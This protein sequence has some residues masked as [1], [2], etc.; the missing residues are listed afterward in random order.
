MPK[1]LRALA[2]LLATGTAWAQT[3]PWTPTPLP[4]T[5]YFI[6]LPSNE[7]VL[8]TPAQTVDMGTVYWNGTTWQSSIVTTGLQPIGANEVL[9]NLNNTAQIPVGCTQLPPGFTI[10]TIN[11]TSVPMN[12]LANQILVTTASATAAWETIPN[13]NAT[14]DALQYN[15]T[16][17]QITCVTISSSGGVTI[18]ASAQLLNSGTGTNPPVGS[19]SLGTNLSLTGT[20]PSQTLNAASTAST[21]WNALVPGVNTNATGEFVIGTGASL[22]TNGTAGSIQA[23]LFQPNALVVSGT[24]PSA[25][26]SW[27]YMTAPVSGTYTSIGASPPRADQIYANYQ[28]TINCPNGGDI[29]GFLAANENLNTG[30]NGTRGSEFEI[31]INAPPVSGNTQNV[32]ALLTKVNMN[33]DMLGVY[34]EHSLSNGNIFGFNPNIFANSAIH[35]YTLTTTSEF[36][37]QLPFGSTSYEKHGMNIATRAADAAQGVISDEALVFANGNYPASAWQCGICFAQVEHDSP[38]TFSSTYLGANYR[39]FASN[40]APEVGWGVDFHQA[41]IYPGLVPTA[42]T[43][44]GT[45]ATLTFSSTVAASSPSGNGTTATVL[46]APQVV[47]P[48]VGSPL[49]IAGQTGAGYNGSFTITAS[50]YNSVSYA[51]TTTA[52]C[53]TNCAVGTATFNAPV[54]P[55]VGSTIIVQNM[56]PAAYDTPASG[57][58]VTGAT[59]TTIS[60]ASTGT[61]TLTQAGNIWSPTTSGAFVKS[62]GYQVDFQGNEYANSVNLNQGSLNGITG[63]L[64]SLT[65]VPYGGYTGGAYSP[66][67][68]PTITIDPP[69]QRA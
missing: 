42:A 43:G 61:G 47:P 44:T 10:T 40:Y 41:Q 27:M 52:N 62:K 63:S 37:V 14:N 34:G 28:D 33:S 8:G 24:G 53:G 22:G 58:I 66:G 23:T 26:N 2:L 25:A 35:A 50:T 30:W 69:R 20:F 57:A 49:T 55:P 6:N 46:I 65:I 64:Q 3:Y 48:A 67:A 31:T 18:P 32:N 12:T 68:F 13:C 56:K 4:G 15:T 16:N 54:V 1:I 39:Y 19:V 17:Q 60:Y 59:A 9:C 11:G 36:D 5:F 29:C 45:T 21:N 51:N 38:F 7:L